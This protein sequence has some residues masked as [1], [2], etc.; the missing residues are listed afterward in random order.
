MKKT[1]TLFFILFISWVPAQTNLTYF[2]GF[3]SPT[4]I[5]HWTY[6]GEGAHSPYS[7]EYNGQSAYSTPTCLVHYYPVGGTSETIDWYISPGFFLPEGAMIDSLR[8][9]FSGFGMPATADSVAIYVLR[10]SPLPNQATSKT[11]IAD[12]R[13]AP[14]YS[15]DGVWRKLTNLA[16][17]GHSTDSIYL[18]FKYKTV[19]NWLDVRFDNLAIRVINTT[20]IKQTDMGVEEFVAYPNPAEKGVR[21]MKDGKNLG[22]GEYTVRFYN[23]AGELLEQKQISEKIEL[24]YSPG[25]YFYTVLNKQSQVVNSG[26]LILR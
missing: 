26:K 13:T 5:A 24:D 10:G 2:T 12:F 6:Y 20:S 16:I 1:F 9:H 23:L 15:N 14:S 19:N 3:D 4:Q 21:F 22:E 25:I 11:L 8:Y 18:A 17:P 7:W